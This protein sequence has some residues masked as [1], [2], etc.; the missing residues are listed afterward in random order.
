[1]ATTAGM[2]VRK[3]ELQLTAV[4]GKPSMATMDSSET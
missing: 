3:D 2:A 4:G 1:M